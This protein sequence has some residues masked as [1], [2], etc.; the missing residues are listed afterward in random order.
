MCKQATENAD[1]PIINTEIDIAKNDDKTVTILG[2]DVDLIVLSTN[3]FFF[4]N[5]AQ[6]IKRIHTYY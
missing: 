3:S 6:E 5:Q 2:K 1:F 4:T